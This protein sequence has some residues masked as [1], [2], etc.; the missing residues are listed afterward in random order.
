[1]E[2]SSLTQDDIYIS[3]IHILSILFDQLLHNRHC[4]RSISSTKDGM[5]I[6]MMVP[7]QLAMPV[8]SH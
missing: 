1:M 8:I 5:M 2:R 4:S 3:S 7:I 6:Q